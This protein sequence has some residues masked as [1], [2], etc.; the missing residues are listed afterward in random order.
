MLRF[1]LALALFFIVANPATFKLTRKVFSPIASADGLPSQLGVLVHALVFVL[2]TRQVGRLMSRYA[3][4]TSA[5]ADEE[6]YEDEKY[7]EEAEKYEEESKYE[8]E[9]YAEEY[10]PGLSPGAY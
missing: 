8:D 2:L 10:T 6:K 7:A 1:L 3:D 5:Y 4:E 9:K